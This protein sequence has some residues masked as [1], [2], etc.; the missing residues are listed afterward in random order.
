MCRFGAP[1][2]GQTPLA[3]PARSEGPDFGLPGERREEEPEALAAGRSPGAVDGGWAWGV[4][5]HFFLVN[6]LVIGMLKTFGIFFVAFQEEVGGSSEQVSWIGSIMSSLRFLGAPLVAVVCRR[7]GERP[8]S[9][10]GAGLVGGGCLL[11]TL[12]TSVP[13]LCVSMGLLL[14]VGFACLYQAA[15]VMTA[16]CCRTRLAFSNAIARSGMGLTFL[17]APFTQ[18][19][20]DFYGWQGTLLIFGGI[21]LNLVPSSMLLRPISTQPPQRCSANDQ[22][23]GFLMAKKDSDTLGGCLDETTRGQ[24]RLRSAQDLSATEGLMMSHGRDVS[25]PGNTSA[26]GRLEKS[27]KDSCSPEI[28]TEAKR[29]HPSLP[30]T[31]KKNSQ[32][33]L[34]FSPLKDPVFCIFTWS[35]LF[36][37][38]AYFVPIFHL[39]AR[40][41]TLG[42]SSM[43]ASYL[44]SVAGITE[45]VSQLLSGWVADQNWTKKYH[46]HVA[47]LV[48]GGIT[49]LLCPLAT[50]FPLLM[51]YAVAFAIFCGGFMALILPVLV[52]LVGVQKL[53]SYLGF[54][55]FFAG[56]AAVGGP[57]L[58]GWLYDYTQTYVCSFLFA[59]A[60]ALVSPISFFFEPSAQKW[61]LKKAN[62]SNGPRLG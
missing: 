18:L 20:I 13:F 16:K 40:A 7:L 30:A 24:T 23:G 5:L 29:S 28:A 17:I 8:T 56:I 47:Y 37:H 12:A 25:G 31:E 41:K 2:E 43:D 9:I 26:L 33:L 49:N 54:A 11:S 46:Y 10:I 51:T 45:T 4:V 59:G 36:S 22:D 48:L 58:A 21:M 35:F 44:I 1:W 19:L 15:A 52:D 55:A 61:K 50:T 38:L 6:V 32:P 60:C 39:V 53:H 27:P 57:P 34:D 14:G 42:I 3:S 62:L